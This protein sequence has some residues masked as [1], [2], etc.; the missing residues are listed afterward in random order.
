MKFFYDVFISI[1][2]AVLPILG[3]FFKR[4]K[5]FRT[6]REINESAF[7]NFVANNKSPLIW[8]HAAS[9]G[10]YEQ[11]VPVIENLK[12]QFKTHK[13]LLTFFSDSGFRVK[14]NTSFADL[15]HYLPLDT[16]KNAKQFV[17][18]VKPDFTIF[19]K[20][21]VWPNFLKELRQNNV[22][23]YLVSARFRP[24]QVYF[25]AYGS[26]FRN[27]LRSFNFIFVQ[28]KESGHL[29]NSIGYT[30]WQL[31]GDTRYDRVTQ[32]L[33]APK[34]LDFMD[35]FVGNNFCFVG[36]STWQE[37]HDMISK[38]INTLETKVKY[39]IAPHQIHEDKIQKL[40]NSL[41]KKSIRYTQIQDQNLAE[42]DVLIVDTIGLLTKIYAYANVAYVGGALGD[43]G[44]HNILE[45]A[46]FGIPVLI[47]PNYKK[48]PEAQELRDANGL[49]VVLDNKDLSGF[50]NLILTDKA[51]Y[52]S[53]CKVAKAFV[54]SRRGA[55]KV[56]TQKILEEN[57]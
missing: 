22:K 3:L 46:V 28:N 23:T 4:L 31:S 8:L 56:I 53:M 9:L 33:Y 37:G 38:V 51:I 54:E 42:Y 35:K 7:K 45:P 14:K 34:E 26:V 49:K 27:A 24:N 55:T 48:F 17:N 12:P 30:N 18:Q 15:V 16:P 5:T 21:D 29:L 13:I 44:L 2:Q 47:G 40:E 41:T 6:E 11:A 36:G 57:N 52:Q 10:E 32:L 19:I 39:V 25:K 50:L 43:T 20:Y 1:F